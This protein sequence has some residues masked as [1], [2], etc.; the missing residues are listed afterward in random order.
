M[1]K[2][3]ISV[4]TLS[5]F[6]I[7]S[8]VVGGAISQADAIATCKHVCHKHDKKEECVKHCHDCK[9]ECGKTHPKD[10]QARIECHKKCNEKAA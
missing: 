1:K 2:S 6:V 3:F 8:A 4:L 9:K 5:L 7:G 10:K